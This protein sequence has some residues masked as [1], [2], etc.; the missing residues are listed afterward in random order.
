[1]KTIFLAE[2]Y[3][4]GLRFENGDIGQISSKTKSFLENFFKNKNFQLFIFPEKTSIGEILEEIN[5]TESG[6]VLVGIPNHK[7][8]IDLIGKIQLSGHKVVIE[9]GVEK[10]LFLKTNICTIEER[11]EKTTNFFQRLFAKTEKFFCRYNF[12]WSSDPKWD[13]YQKIAS[14]KNLPQQ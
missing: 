12:I 2:A 14:P 4:K 9:Q 3:P 7:D 11:V 10:A 13:F 5:K 1:M 8:K 6:I